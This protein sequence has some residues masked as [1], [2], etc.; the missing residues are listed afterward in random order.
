V[1]ALFS[2]GDVFRG[3]TKWLSAFMFSN[4]DFCDRRKDITVY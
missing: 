2:K 4:G 3:Y 1:A